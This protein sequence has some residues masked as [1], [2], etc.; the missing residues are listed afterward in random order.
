MESWGFEFGSAETSGRV[1]LTLDATRRRTGFVCDLT[2]PALGRVV[3]ADESLPMPRPGAGLEI[4]GEGLWV[5]LSCEV[6]FQHWSLG[7][8]AFGLIVDPE[9]V[10]EG[11]GWEGLL[12]ERVPVGFDLE[13]ELR[14]PPEFLAEGMGYTQPGV[15]VGV[16]LVAR[17]R[18]DVDAPS[19]RDHWWGGSRSILVE[20]ADHT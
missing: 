18:L 4:R 14:G 11:P 10:I 5:W 1:R 7:M 20:H 15:V 8:E 17:E 9:P 19:V 16:I 6:P 13:W 12:G 3:V 2:D